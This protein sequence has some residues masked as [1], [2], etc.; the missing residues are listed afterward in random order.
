MFAIA[1]TVTVGGKNDL[2]ANVG[3]SSIKWT[4]SIWLFIYYKNTY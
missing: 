1:N 4:T 2:V 3:G